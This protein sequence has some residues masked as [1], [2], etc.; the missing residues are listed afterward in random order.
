[1]FVRSETKELGG[2]RGNG[3][4]LTS[5]ALIDECE[6]LAGGSGVLGGRALLLKYSA[7]VNK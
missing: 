3:C 6:L 7:A 4:L 2:E 5:S 1:M